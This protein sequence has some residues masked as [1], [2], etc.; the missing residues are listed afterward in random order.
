[1]A[2]SLIGYWLGNLAWEARREARLRK[3]EARM[4]VGL[5]KVTLTW[6]F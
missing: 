1:V 4:G 5:D 2:G 6:D 3:N